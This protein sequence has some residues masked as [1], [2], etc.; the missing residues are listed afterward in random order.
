M[1]ILAQVLFNLEIKYFSKQVR[2]N[3][4]FG[5]TKRKTQASP[6]FKHIFSKS[7]SSHVH[8]LI[9]HSCTH[10]AMF[11]YSLQ[12]AA[13]TQP[14]S[15]THYT[16]PAMFTYSLQTAAHIQPCSR[17]HYTQLHTSSH[18]HVLIALS[19]THPVMFTYSLH[20]A[21]HIQPCSRTHYGVWTFRRQDVSTTN[22]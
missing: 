13:H 2:N 19:C 3:L 20:T 21:A 17:T 18:V 8:V 15:R 7:T 1:S 14:C 12:R 22:R 16:H 6:T 5:E 9:T 10:P 11:T 4:H